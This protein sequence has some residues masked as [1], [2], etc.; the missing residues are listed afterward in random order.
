MFDRVRE[1]FL[2]G[3]MNAERRIRL[4]DNPPEQLSKSV[5]LPIADV[6][7][8]LDQYEKIVASHKARVEHL[9]AINT[10]A[11]KGIAH[12]NARIERL[13][14][15]LRYHSVQWHWSH[16]TETTQEERKANCSLCTALKEES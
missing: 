12:L 5:A 10:G 14:A 16:N 13:E 15:A 4:G 8:L 3:R 9:Q 7:Y 2:V 1:R 6:K 11:A